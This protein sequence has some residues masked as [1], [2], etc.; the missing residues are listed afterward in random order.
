M[1][2]SMKFRAS[3]MHLRSL[4]DT[5]MLSDLLAGPEE[6]LALNLVRLGVPFHSV[7]DELR[8]DLVRLTEGYS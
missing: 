2:V 4:V 8:H 6:R 3:R 5:L 7:A 1:R